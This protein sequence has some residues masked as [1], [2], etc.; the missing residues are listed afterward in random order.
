[1]K[2]C[3][4]EPAY[5]FSSSD[6]AVI[7][8]NYPAEI[9][10]DSTRYSGTVAAQLKYFPASR[11]ALCG[12]FHGVD[13]R[14]ALR[15][16]LGENQVE[17]FSIKN[18]KADGGLSP[19]NYDPNR[20]IFYIDLIPRKEPVRVYHNKKKKVTSVLFHLL[21]FTNFV[22]QTND[23]NKPYEDIIFNC[24][25]DGWV[26]SI[27]ILPSAGD[28]YNKLKKNG[29]YQL[30]HVGRI[31]KVDAE[32]FSIGDA[33][34][35]LA[36]FFLFMS[37]INGSIVQPVSV[38]G[39]DDS[40]EKS[41][42]LFYSPREPWREPLRWL[43]PKNGK[44]IYGFLQRFIT[45]YRSGSWNKAFR[46]AI[47]WYL[48]ANNDA[49]GIDA[50]IILTQAAI[51]RLSFEYAVNEKRFV[52]RKSFKELKASDKFRLLFS[53]LE[54][55]IDFTEK[56][57]DLSRISKKLKFVDAPHAL[58]EVRNSLVHPDNKHRNELN[59][60]YFDSWNLGLWYLEAVISTLCGLDGYYG[61]RLD[62]FARR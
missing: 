29:G 14:Q 4:L 32:N 42:E 26:I 55:P 20:G 23:T 10:I 17:S 48:N 50:G 60:A 46:E 49:R 16:A 7:L 35:F 25:L 1:M 47:Y 59:E 57:H 51:E 45:K 56:T 2:A 13:K 54:I 9:L 30:T 37:F 43:N 24:S 53:S 19:A 39:F 44:Q 31:S 15:A 5:D 21:N 34:D 52:E 18:I 61:S 62:D 58:T 33:E 27:R 3:R 12:S 6:T 28:S 36:T 22:F 8:G 11:I 40:C 41:V 38:I